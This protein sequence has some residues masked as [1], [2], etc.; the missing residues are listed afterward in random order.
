M[1]FDPEFEPVIGLE[2][3]AQLLTQTK[4]FCRCSTLFN[5]PS[6]SNVCPICTGQPGAL[7]VLNHKAV[8]FAVRAGLALNCDIKKRSVFSRK[9]YFYA[10]LPKGYQISQFDEPICLKGHIEIQ[11]KGAATTKRVGI[12]R[13]HMEE[14]AGKSIHMEGYSMVNLNRSSVPLIEIVSE[15]DIRSSDEAGAYLRGLHSI[16]M[17]IGINDGN[18]QEGSFRCDANVSVRPRGTEKFG[19]RAEIKNVNSF[20]FVEK[21]ID[22]EIHRQIEVIKAGGKVVQETRGFDSGRGA[23]YSLRSKEEAHDYRYFPEPDLLPLNIT[24]SFID[25]VKKELPELPHQKKERFI[26]SFGIPAYD[27]G[28]IVASKALAEFF[29]STVKVCGEAKT[30]SNWVMGELLRMLKTTDGSADVVTS[31]TLSIP[32]TPKAL[33][34]LILLIKNGTISN[35][36]AKTVF[37]EMF[38]SGHSPEQIV[39]EKGLAQVSDT[40]VLEKTIDAIFAANATQLAEYRSGKEKLFGFFVGQAMKQLAGKANPQ[41]INDLLKRKL[42]G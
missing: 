35:S 16:L 36:I 9:N 3:H 12:T 37:E 29:E 8:E 21:A 32:V 7:P 15:P 23:T 41:V 2:V 28:V 42:K 13:I 17:Y 1:A 39:Q 14:D 24:S 6:N 20:R 31:P 25:G 18:L 19:T 11:L 10:D 22:F 26:S 5:S 4:L 40:S 33:G 27:A 38:V 30:V 34:E